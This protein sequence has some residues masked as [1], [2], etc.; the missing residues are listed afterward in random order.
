M[1]VPAV[2]HASGQLWSAR[3]P[4]GLCQAIGQPTLKKLGHFG[5]VQ[6]RSFGIRLHI[7]RSHRRDEQRP[8]PEP[9]EQPGVILNRYGNLSATQ[10]GGIGDIGRRLSSRSWRLSRENLE[11]PAFDEIDVADEPIAGRLH[12]TPDVF[13]GRSMTNAR[14]TVSSYT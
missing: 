9:A 1:A 10:P 5:T 4:L 6:G 14:P 12:F 3:R 2:R 7:S 11:V 8:V 13:F